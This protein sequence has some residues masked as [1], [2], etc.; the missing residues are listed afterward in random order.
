MAR[1]VADAVETVAAAVAA[2]TSIVAQ[3]LRCVA[4]GIE[5]RA[6]A[7]GGSVRD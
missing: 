6:K 1:A 5:Q 7:A 2:D 3:Y 4:A